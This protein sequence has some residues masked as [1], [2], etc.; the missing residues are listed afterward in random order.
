M[1]DSVVFDRKPAVKELEPGSYA[2]CRC[3]RSKSQP[4]CDGSHKGTGIQPVVFKLEEKKKA[5]LC[6]CKQTKTPPFCDGTHRTVT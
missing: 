6:L 1:A 4:F 2:W 5:A 3:G